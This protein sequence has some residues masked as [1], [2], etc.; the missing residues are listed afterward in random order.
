MT[1]QVA[2]N[3]EN[4]VMRIQLMRPEAKNALNHAMYAAMADALIEANTSNDIRCVV[5]T[6]SE[7]SFTAGNDLADFA[8]EMPEG[9]WPV[10]R[11][12]NT[13]RDM[14]TPVLVA[15]NGLAVGVGVTMLL[16]S[17]LAFAS[18]AASFSAPFTKIGLVP[19]A[20]SSLL[21]PL[22][23]GNAW[24]NDMLLANRKLDAQEALSAGLVSRVLPADTLLSTAIDVAENIAA[25]APG[26]MSASKRLIRNQRERVIAQM[27]AE[28]EI[29]AAQL[30]SPEFAESVAAMMEK[31]LPNFE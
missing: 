23:V 19:E 30:K 11:F 10:M 20:G 8:A 18:K 27:Q 9:E 3:T 22:A 26:A 5:L 14:D 25:L 29:F 12:L 28:G 21:L 13:L 7:D 17:D 4:R 31:R 1:A 6:G 16:H 2:I 24:A 15:I